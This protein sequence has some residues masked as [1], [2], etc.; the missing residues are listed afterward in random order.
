MVSSGIF[1]PLCSYQNIHRE[2]PLRPVLGQFHTQI[3]VEGSC[4]AFSIIC[5]Y[6]IVRQTLLLHCEKCNLNLQR[7]IIIIV[8]NQFLYLKS[9]L[10]SRNFHLQMG[11]YDKA[12]SL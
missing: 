6:N 5:Y 4:F 12:P 11:K 8:N 9:N 2:C 3:N 7:R 10:Y 1:F